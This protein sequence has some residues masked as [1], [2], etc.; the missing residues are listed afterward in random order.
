M[1]GPLEI[2]RGA[3]PGMRIFAWEWRAAMSHVV[4]WVCALV[5]VFCQ[6][7]PNIATIQS[8]YDREAS[9]GSALHDK[10]LKILRA[11]CHAAGAGGFLCDVIFTSRDDP[12]GRL[13]VD[14][15][16]V[17]RRDDG[18]ELKSGLCKR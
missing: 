3:S 6:P 15:V 17:A 1:T 8:V 18:W 10:G 4:G 5:G 14:V 2:S 7:V 9:E 11:S 13:Y 12:A 16:E